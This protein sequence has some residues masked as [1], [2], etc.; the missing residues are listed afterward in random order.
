MTTGNLP[1]KKDME[2]TVHRKPRWFK[3]AEYSW[4]YPNNCISRKYP[5]I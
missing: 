3:K 5:R 1:G 4:K 2:R